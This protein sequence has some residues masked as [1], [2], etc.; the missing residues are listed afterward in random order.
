MGVY[1][2]L[3]ICFPT[4]WVSLPCP[5]RERKVSQRCEHGR[6]RRLL[7]EIKDMTRRCHAFS[8]AIQPAQV[9]TRDLGFGSHW[10]LRRICLPQTIIPRSKIDNGSSWRCQAWLWPALE[11]NNPFRSWPYVLFWE[12]LC[13]WQKGHVWDHGRLCN[14]GCQN[15]F[16]CPFRWQL[17]QQVAPTVAAK[18]GTRI[19][20][21]HFFVPALIRTRCVPE[22]QSCCQLERPIYSVLILFPRLLGFTRWSWSGVR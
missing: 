3:D 16:S 12:G 17:E 18:D 6:S 8:I 15:P 10:Q 14:V 1:R 11:I 9:D 19:S 7:N 13:Q 21:C 20:C 5:P 4:S 22:L 2:K